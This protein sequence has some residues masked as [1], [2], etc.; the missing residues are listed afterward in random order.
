[1][2]KRDKST[3]LIGYRSS[4]AGRAAR[5]DPRCAERAAALKACRASTTSTSAS[6]PT[7]PTC[8]PPG[9]AQPLSG[10]DDHRPAAPVLGP[11]ARRDLLL[12]DPAVRRPAQAPVACPM[13]P[14]PGST[15]P[16]SSSC[17]SSSRPLKP[18]ADAESA[19][20]ACRTRDAA[21]SE[22][23]RSSRSTS[24][25]RSEPP[26]TDTAASRRQAPSPTTPSSQRFLRT[27]NQPTGSQTLGF[28]MVGVSQA[29]RASRS[30]ST[31]GPSCC[32]TR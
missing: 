5:G 28:R 22:S 14:S 29:T 17:C 8:I 7:R 1:M 23:P 24:S 30:S 9:P 16:A 19:P 21:A 18:A 2:A 11:G 20:P 26:M 27:K 12:G 32:S 15:I 10:R 25:G 6:A 13:R 4:A 31:P 3:D